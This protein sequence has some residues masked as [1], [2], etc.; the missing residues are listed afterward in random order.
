MSSS[1]SCVGPHLFLVPQ[2]P[3]HLVRFWPIS[4]SGRKLSTSCQEAFGVCVKHSELISGLLGCVIHLLN[5]HGRRRGLVPGITVVPRTCFL[6]LVMRSFF[7][8]CI[9]HLDALFH[10]MILYALCLTYKWIAIFT[11][12]F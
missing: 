8:E 3:A 12:E 6:G 2:S 7:Y 9:W 10:E 11:V 5:G 4:L 1:T